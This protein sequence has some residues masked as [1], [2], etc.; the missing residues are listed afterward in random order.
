MPALRDADFRYAATFALDVPGRHGAARTHHRPRPRFG[1]RAGTPVFRGWIF[2][3]TRAS[4]YHCLRARAP[5]DLAGARRDG[6]RRGDGGPAITDMSIPRGRTSSSSS[7]S[8]EISHGD[9]HV[10]IRTNAQIY[11]DQASVAT[12][13]PRRRR[14]SR[15]CRRGGRRALSR[16]FADVSQGRAVRAALVRLRSV[17]ADRP[18]AR[19]TAGSR[20]TAT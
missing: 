16:V 3:P 4:T 15:G 19:S 2:P 14:R 7:T 12:T 18:G 1:A 13:A 6:S 5:V 17:S 9:H 20:A 10:R 8:P 11:W